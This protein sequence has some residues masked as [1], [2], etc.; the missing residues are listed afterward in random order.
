MWRVGAKRIPE[1]EGQEAVFAWANGSAEAETI[2][3]AVRYALQTLRALAPGSSVE[4]RVPPYAAIQAI[5]GPT[6]TRGTPP[7]VVEMAPDVCLELVTGRLGFHEGVTKG[8]IRASGE[9]SDISAW[10]PFLEIP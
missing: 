1:R 6:H 7:A 10:L 5:P 2:A 3:L 9:R 8:L 4:V